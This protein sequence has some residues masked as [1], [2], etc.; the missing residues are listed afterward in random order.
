M[1]EPVNHFDR[2]ITVIENVLKKNKEEVGSDYDNFMRTYR[3]GLKRIKGTSPIE[4]GKL[5][6][7]YDNEKILLKFVLLLDELKKLDENLRLI[8]NIVN[9]HGG[10]IKFV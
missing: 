2:I 10:S 7:L 5:I 8:N 3:R 1:M 6:K 9:S 4:Y